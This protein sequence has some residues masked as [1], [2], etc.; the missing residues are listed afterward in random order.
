MVKRSWVRHALLS[1]VLL[2]S[3]LALGARAARADGDLQRLNHIIIAMQ[4]NHSFDNYLGVL[5][6]VPN[7]PYHPGRLKGPRHACAATDHTCVD[8]LTCVVAR[9]TGELTCLN[10]IPSNTRGSVRSFHEPRYCTGP[11]LDHS[12]TGSHEE[13]NF[14]RPNTMLRSSPNNGFVKVNAQTE[15]P[16]QATDHD[17][18]GYYT[19]ADL[20][21]YYGLAE[22]FAIS[23]RYFA[24]ALGPTFPNRSYLLAGTS[25]GHLTTDEIIGP[26]LPITG[27]IFDQLDAHGISWVDYAS[28]VP[29]SALMFHVS[30]GHQKPVTMFATDAAAGTLP[31]VAF[32]DPSFVADQAINGSQYETDEHPPNDI[33]AGEY[34]VSQIITALRNSPSWHDSILFLTYDEHGGFYDHVKPPAA[35]QGDALT[36]DGIAPGQCA[37]ASNPPASEE[38]GGG[39]NCADSKTMDAP[40]LCSAFTP[41]GTYPSSCATFDQ[42]GFRLPLIAVSPFAKPH[43]VSH[44]IGSHTSLLALIERRFSLPSLTARDANANDLEDLFDFDSSP[45]LSAMV[46]TAPLPRQPPAVTPGDPGCPF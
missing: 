45:S 23:D 41:T 38:P 24:A 16:D 13:G 10:S 40:M 46:G 2:V 27:T 28:D 43:Y 4:E 32:V 36:P 25:F 35:L 6:Y 15:A 14:R 3:A 11:D 18:M 30:A 5:A 39:A 7:S 44:V 9:R 17:T 31:A 21:F 37:D 19:D 34:F 29:Y 26:Y 1:G 22:T 42:L 20:P 33:R 12:W 8:G